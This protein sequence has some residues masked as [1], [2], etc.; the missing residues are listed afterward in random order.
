MNHRQS[1]IPSLL[2]ATSSHILDIFQ[3][4]KILMERASKILIIA[5]RGPDA[6]AVGANLALREA[7]ERIGKKVD[8]ACVD[9]IPE[10]SIFLSQSEKFLRDF[11]SEDYDLMISVDCGGH[12]QLGFHES[13]P[14]L[15]DRTK[16]LFINIDHH[17]SNDHFGT[18]N[19]VMDETPSTCF[20]LHLMFSSYGWE[21]TPNMATALLHGLY[22]DTGSFMHSNTCSDTLRIAGRLLALGADHAR[23]IKE[24]FKT[25]PLSRLKLW[26]RGLERVHFNEHHALTSLLTKNDFLETKTQFED[27]SGLVQ[28][29]NHVPEARFTMLLT[30]T[31]SGKI[32]ASMRTQNDDID[33]AQIAN[34][35]GGGGHKKAAGFTINGSLRPKV[36]WSI[37]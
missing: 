20:I 17:S 32:K 18:V 9:P 3:E 16:I 36:T 5:H 15:L 26:G 11:K 27:S 7:L 23:C 21:I 33:L 24:Q 30:E 4:A 35:F 29:L 6:D 37:H 14:E 10:N 8:S 34:L 25:T 12:K 13:K 2:T 19:I 28:Y 22:Y 1:F 31:D